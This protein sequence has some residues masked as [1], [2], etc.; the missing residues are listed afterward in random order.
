VR[1]LASFSTSLNFKPPAFENAAMYPNS[2]TY[3]AT[4]DDR[5]MF[6]PILV[7]L[8]P[9]TAENRSVQVY[10]QLEAARATPFLFRFNHD[11]MPSL[12]S[13]NL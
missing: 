3:N 7:K 1:N 6:L 10:Q 12:K 8:S 2:E 5:P 11:T 4:Q 9:R 13:L